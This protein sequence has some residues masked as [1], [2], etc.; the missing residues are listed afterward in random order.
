MG[1][2]YRVIVGLDFVPSRGVLSNTSV[3]VGTLVFDI[4]LRLFFS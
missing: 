3:P 2:S 4:G 1:V